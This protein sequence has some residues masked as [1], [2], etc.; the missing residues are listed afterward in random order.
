[1]A[2][3]GF[4]ASRFRRITI[5]VLLGVVLAY[6]VTGTLMEWV[7]TGDFYL[8]AQD[9]RMGV[10]GMLFQVVGGYALLKAIAG[11]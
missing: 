1:V 11:R 7:L 10:P 9:F 3:A 8:A 4:M 2:A 5:P 6:Q